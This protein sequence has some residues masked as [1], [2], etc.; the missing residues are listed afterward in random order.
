MSEDYA[1]LGKLFPKLSPDELAA[2]KE[3][4][5]AYLLLAWEIWESIRLEPTAINRV[6]QRSTIPN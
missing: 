3:S 4:L 5:D 6:Q 1:E 2:A